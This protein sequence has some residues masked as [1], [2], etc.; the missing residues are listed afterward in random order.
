MH[1]ACAILCC[2]LWPVQLYNTFP[3]YL[4][5]STIFEGGKVTEH[6]CVWVFST[7]LSEI[8]IIL[9]RTRQDFTIYVNR[10]TCKVTIILLKFSR[11]T[12]I[13]NSIKV[14]PAAFELL[15]ADRQMELIFAFDNS[16]NAH[17]TVKCR[18]NERQYNEMFRIAKKFL[19]PCPFPYL[20]CVKTFH[21][22]E[23]R[24]FSI[25]N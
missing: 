1:N 7:I 17:N 9:K 4:I 14:C 15:N 3:H 5:N 19:G 22:N 6:M 18:C 23:F 2:P 11:N 25:T 24:T 21:F 10:C 8:I 12:Q 16:A 13:S 20:M